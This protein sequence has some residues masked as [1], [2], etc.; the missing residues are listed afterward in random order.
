MGREMEVAL[1]DQM[2]MHVKCVFIATLKLWV[3][4]V[5]IIKGE[6]VDAQACSLVRNWRLSPTL[7]VA[8]WRVSGEARYLTLIK[9]LLIINYKIS[10]LGLF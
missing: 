1:R 5:I 6:P 3:V 7:Y 4:K 9:L 10:R 2:V 8:D